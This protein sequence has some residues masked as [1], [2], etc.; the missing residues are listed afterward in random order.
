MDNQIK[1][2]PHATA[3]P[4]I[5]SNSTSISNSQSNPTVIQAVAL[6][7]N[8]DIG[9]CR[10]CGEEFIRPPGIHDGVAQY[11]RYLRLYCM[12]FI[13]VKINHVLISRCSRRCEKC[14]DITSF[15]GDFLCTIS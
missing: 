14:S 12:P 1:S 6:P 10:G 4:L 3:I 13:I 5:S 9:V 11:Y 2:F 15:C 8:Q 7:H